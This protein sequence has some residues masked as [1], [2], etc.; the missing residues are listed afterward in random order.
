MACFPRDWGGCGFVSCAACLCVARW[1]DSYRAIIIAGKLAKK[2]SFSISRLFFKLENWSLSWLCGLNELAKFGQWYFHWS[3]EDQWRNSVK[4]TS[5]QKDFLKASFINFLRGPFALGHQSRL[6]FINLCVDR[7][8][9]VRVVALIGHCTKVWQIHF[10]LFSWWKY[11]REIFKSSHISFIVQIRA[12]RNHV[13]IVSV[14]KTCCCRVIRLDGVVIKI[15]PD[16][17]KSICYN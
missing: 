14:Q 10:L 3:Y 5:Q 11:S 16:W 17:R 15:L 12:F 7:S 4:S 6:R 13:T 8:S 9:S 2:W 1:S